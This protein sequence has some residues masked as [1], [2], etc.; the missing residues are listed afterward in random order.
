MPFL[1]LLT[2]LTQALVWKF[3]WQKYILKLVP[4]YLVEGLLAGIGLKIALKFLPF[5][6]L[7]YSDH[8]HASFILDTEHEIVMILS[9]LSFITV[10]FR[11]LKLMKTITSFNM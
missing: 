2:S 7:A 10:L 1:I 6:Y 9:I 5:T 3:N 11:L 4:N 8:Q